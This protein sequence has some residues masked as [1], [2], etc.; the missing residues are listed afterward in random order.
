MSKQT[1]E[2]QISN[3]EL[4]TM[5]DDLDELNNDV[6]VPAMAEADAWMLESVHEEVAAEEGLASRRLG[7]RTFLL[8]AGAVA[9][10]LALAAC[11]G[12]T[13]GNGGNTTSTGPP[14]TT[15][16]TLKT[17]LA[18]TALATAVENQAVTTYNNAANA[19]IANKFGNIPKA[20]TNFALIAKTQHQQHADAWNAILVAAKKPKVTTGISQGPTSDAKVAARLTAISNS[21]N[22]VKL[23]ELALQLENTAAQTYQVG[24][25]VVTSPQGIA[26][27]ASIQPVEMQHAAILYYVLGKYPGIQDSSGNPVSFN[28]TGNAAMTS[29]YTGQV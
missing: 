20:A 28:P 18:V 13:T 1:N 22:L 19:V 17:D 10:G 27:A 2:I 16:M 14:T 23:L 12:S 7:R 24:S 8:G 4:Q 15:A 11:G 29:Y 26:L 9:G 21:G 3:A 5:V 6:A 25:T